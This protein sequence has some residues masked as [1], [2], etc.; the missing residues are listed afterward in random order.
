MKKF[1]FFIATIVFFS[2]SEKSE[3]T[4]A[5]NCNVSNKDAKKTITD[6]RR[7]FEINIPTHWKTELFYNQSSSEIYSADTTKQLT[8]TYILDVSHQLGEINFD[9]HFIKK[10]DSVLKSKKLF[11]IKSNT[12]TFK[13][14]PAF[15][16]ITQGTNKRFVVNRLNLLVKTSEHEYIAA[17][18]EVYGNEQIEE[19][20]CDGISILNTLKL[21]D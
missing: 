13:Q 6:F 7:N 16:Y 5:F 3:L 10:N 11:K 14:Y 8:N 4:A 21:L 19:R 20:F 15:Y 1:I 18:C 12:L 2:C 9:N 17:Y